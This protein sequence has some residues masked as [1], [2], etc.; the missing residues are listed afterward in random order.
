LIEEDKRERT[1]VTACDWGW[2]FEREA[3]KD[4]SQVEVLG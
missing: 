4:A 1:V 3:A 2:E